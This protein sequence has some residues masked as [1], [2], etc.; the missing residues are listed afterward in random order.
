MADESARLERY[1]ATLR[2]RLGSRR[3]Q[4]GLDA[5][6]RNPGRLR[7]VLSTLR[8][9]RS[10]DSE[11]VQRH[12][13]TAICSHESDFFAS[14]PSISSLVNSRS[15]QPIERLSAELRTPYVME[16]AVAVERQLPGHTTV[17]L[18]YVNAHGLHQFFTNDINAP[19]P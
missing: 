10:T 13:A 19:L 5:Q 18:A 16:S 11:T 12:R 15:P 8:Y 7:H 3:R 17:A 6:D 1:S 4:S 9:I 2:T 14:I